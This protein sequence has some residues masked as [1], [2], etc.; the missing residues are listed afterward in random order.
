MT[1]SV[2]VRSSLVRLLRR[3]LVGP[4]VGI[5]DADLARELLTE[6][7]S[8]WYL[9]GFIAPEEGGSSA[10]YADTVEQG[11]LGEDLEGEG[12]PEP[13]PVI[14]G[15]KSEDNG[16]PDPGA[17]GRRIQ[18]TSL[19]LTV[20]LQPDV[21][22]IEALITWGDYQV[23]P[24][25]PPEVLISDSE[26]QPAGHL[27]RRQPREVPIRLTVPPDGPASKAVTVP[28][29][30]APQLPGGGLAL[31][32]HARTYPVRQPDGSIEH[33]RA[34][35]VLLVNRRRRPGRYFLDVSCAFQ[36]RLELRCE[37][38]FMPRRDL[39]GHWSDDPDRRLADLQYRDVTEFAVGRA[40]SAGWTTDPDGT[41]RSTWTDP[42]PA[43]E[44]ERVAPNE[45]IDGV[46][47]EMEALS[48]LAHLGAADLAKALA[49]LPQ[50]YGDWI[51]AQSASIALIAGPRRQEMAHR[52]TEAMRKAQG[53]PPCQQD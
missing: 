37:Q 21:Q 9:T 16:E 20:L 12:E 48:K 14:G 31:V 1:A 50:S 34:L 8:R 32:S 4:D 28:G 33:M 24:P 35:T 13:D 53:R 26:K 52:L 44:V 45:K 23:E 3:D 39:S 15:G 40:S 11:V 25:L 17:G 29:S 43:A 22:E 5:D 47:W 49:M 30:A 27:W 19:G 46:A 51:T 7:P 10:S 42:L 36:V 2:D 6:R 41:V 18:P 38:G